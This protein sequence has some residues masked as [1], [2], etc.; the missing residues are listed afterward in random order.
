MSINICKKVAAFLQ[1]YQEKHSWAGWAGL[2]L[3][4]SLSMARHLG[5]KNTRR[6]LVSVLY[7]IQLQYIINFKLPPYIQDDT[8]NLQRV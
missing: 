1:E 6:H 4:A 3:R 5:L 7:S 2:R 8:G